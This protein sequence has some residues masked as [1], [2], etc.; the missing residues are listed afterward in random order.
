MILVTCEKG[1][2]RSVVSSMGNF[3]QMMDLKGFCFKVFEEFW[4]WWFNCRTLA[5]KS[6][7]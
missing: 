4:Q 2:G 1:D 7:V 6:M 5:G 3:V